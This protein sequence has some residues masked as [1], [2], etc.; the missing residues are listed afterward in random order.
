MA[1]AE[2]ETKVRDENT[3]YLT[4]F[5]ERVR[6]GWFKSNDPDTTVTCEPLPNVNI[7][8]YGSA[9]CRIIGE[10]GDY[11]WNFTIITTGGQELQNVALISNDHRGNFFLKSVRN[12][13]G[14]DIGMTNLQEW[15]HSP[16]FSQEDKRQY[17]VTVGFTARKHSTY[18]Q[19]LV[20]GFL[21]PPAHLQRI[22]ADYLHIKDYERIQRA[23]NYQQSQI[24]SRWKEPYEFYS[25]FTPHTNPRQIKLSRIYAY[26]DRQNFSLTQDTLS[27]N[28]L[29]PRN[30]RGRMHEM[31]TLEE[32]ARHEQISRYNHLSWLRLMAHYVLF[33]SD[34]STITKYTPPGEL[35]AQ[36]PLSRDILEDTQSGRLL[37]RSC[38]SVLLRLWHKKNTKH[39]IFEAHI[40]DKSSHSIYVRLSKECVTF[41]E[42]EA[43]NELEVEVQFMLNRLNFCEWHLAVD[44]LEDMDLVFLMTE[45]HKTNNEII[46]D[47]LQVDAGNLSILSSLLLDSPLN[48]EQKQAVTAITLSIKS[49]SPPVLLLGPFGTGKTFTIA[50][51]LRMLVLNTNNR[52]LL[53]THS[54]SAADLYIKEFFHIWYQQ[55]KHP[56]LKPVRIYYKLRSLNTVHPTVLQYCL[57]DEH[58]RFRDPVAEDLQNCGLI[59][60]TLATSSC[61]M[62][63]KL[64]LSHIVIDE[65]A[66]AME[67]EALI[68]LTLANRETRLLLAGDQ[69][70]LAPEIYSV[71]ANERGLGVSLLERMY[72]YYPPEHPCRIHL[73]QNYRAH[74]DIIKYTS[75]TFYDGMVK[76]AN[77]KLLKHPVMKPLIFY[78]VNGAEEQATCSTG[79]HHAT[80]AEEL[81]NRVLELR[82][83]WPTP[84][85]G[86]YDEG[87]I[88]VLSYY[89]EQVQRLRIEL[90]KRRLFDVSVERVLNVQG[91]QFTAVFISTVRTRISDRS[92]AEV[93]IKD[94]G[95]LTDP[96]L[97]NT[98]LTRAK[99]FVAV[100]GDPVALLTIGCCKDLWRKYLEAADLYG[101]DR[102]ELQT[103]L[104]QVSKIQISPLNPHAREFIPRAPPLCFVQYIQVPIFYPVC[105]PPQ[106]PM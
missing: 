104:N 29:T 68:A 102:K 66:Q 61:L 3:P 56:R 94:Y 20:F 101:M 5:P 65:A 36:I 26:P 58:G 18:R 75:E 100:V 7:Y 64:S 80:E 47:F 55:D 23:T 54:N 32:I 33:N 53:C 45:Q 39:D 93:K 85:W 89:P 86:P 19:D 70:Q 28:R 10:K 79:Y 21:N 92:S 72:S 74:A 24:P 40:E 14:A 90:R 77:M 6:Y 34:G 38:N 48:H 69:M 17:L 57:M 50:H 42:L 41:W 71:L 84:Q 9:N 49:S 37:Q 97:L 96:R 98:A 103:H 13:D 15:R 46:R 31:I 4:D 12:K 30:Y 51:M 11:E 60:T 16:D 63:L 106:R 82:K 87:S 1:A 91:K 2:H 83:E 62:S 95:F 52:I 35:F 88:G 44:S 73:C 59:V 99:C 25:S 67:C 8:L 43:H 76:P 78:A 22:C 105:Y 81:A 27:D